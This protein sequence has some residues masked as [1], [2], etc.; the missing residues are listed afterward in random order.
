MLNV[1]KLLK[2]EWYQWYLSPL[3][4]EHFHEMAPTSFHD[5]WKVAE[6]G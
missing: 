1:Y 2:F 5:F 4:S 6:I 3:G